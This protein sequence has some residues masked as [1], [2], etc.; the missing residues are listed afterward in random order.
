MRTTQETIRQ[1]STHVQIIKLKA[2]TIPREVTAEMRTLA[3][4]FAEW[5]GWEWRI[6]TITFGT[7]YQSDALEIAQDLARERWSSSPVNRILKGE[8]IL[9]H[10]SIIMLNRDFECNRF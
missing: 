2:E 5:T 10:K 8:P 9:K 3:A 7:E 6:V 1:S 4:V